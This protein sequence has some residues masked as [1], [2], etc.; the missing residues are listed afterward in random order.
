MERLLVQIYTWITFLKTPL[1]SS[2]LQQPGLVQMD[3]IMKREQNKDKT[4]DQTESLHAQ[5]YKKNSV[6]IILHSTSTELFYISRISQLH[7]TGC[8]EKNTKQTQ[9]VLFRCSLLAH[10]HHGNYFRFH[11]FVTSITRQC[12]PHVAAE[13]TDK[14]IPI[15]FM[16]LKFYTEIV[17]SMKQDVVESIPSRHQ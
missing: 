10:I 2:I 13:L 8:L 12:P 3:L 7:E 9:I 1:P 11:L 4:S 17:I 15:Y 5:S 6:S 16:L 14:A